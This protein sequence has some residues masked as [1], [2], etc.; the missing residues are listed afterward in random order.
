MESETEYIQ[1]TANTILELIYEM[2]VKDLKSGNILRSKG[3]ASF[4]KICK[5]RKSF[6]NDDPTLFNYGNSLN[7]I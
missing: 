7:K 1:R 5:K 4:G 3:I 6:N 2:Y